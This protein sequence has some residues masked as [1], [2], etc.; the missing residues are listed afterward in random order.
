MA[1]NEVLGLSVNVSAKTDD[2]VKA[3]QN[4]AKGAKLNINT[5]GM[6]DNFKSAQAQIKGMFA[7]TVAEAAS[8]GL[9]KTKVEGF[10]KK[11]QPLTDEIEKS[12]KKSF[13][14]D[15]A[16]RKAK[17]G[18]EKYEKIK[19]LKAEEDTRLRM[20]HARLKQEQV[21]SEKILK[22]R[23]EAI[24]EAERLAARTMTEAAEEAGESLEKAFNDIKG[25]NLAGMFKGVGKR[26]G[27]F[28]AGLQEKGEAAGGMKGD[29]LKSLGKILG[30]LG[31]GL[32]AIGALIAGFA[33]LVKIII[34]AD[35]AA[36]ELHRTLLENGTS[37][38][39][40]TNKFGDVTESLATVRDAFT[41]LDF[42]RTWGTTAKDH[43]SVLNAYA[44]AGRT[45]K[46][47]TGNVK[48]TAQQMNLL[49]EATAGAVAYGKLLG[50][51][52]DTMAEHIGQMM[53]EMAVSQEGALSNFSKI[54]KAA[55]ESGFS[56]K[57]FFNMVLQATSGMAMYNVRLEDT[58]GLLLK[59]TKVLGAKAGAEFMEKLNRGY[60][61]A[62]T[63]ERTKDALL[64]GGKGVELA[65]GE[66]TRQAESLAQLVK[67]F[68]EDSA[69][70][71]TTGGAE[72]M[73]ALED[74][75]LAKLL[76]DPKALAEALS[77]M[78]EKDANAL[79]AKLSTMNADLAGKFQSTWQAALGNK[80]SL[81]GVQAS[82]EQFG[83][84]AT[85][86]SKMYKMR[87]VGID[88]VD[89]VSY[90]DIVKRMG[91]EAVSGIS[92][93]DF[94]QMKRLGSL[95]T[96]FQTNLA[97]AQAKMKANPAESEKIAEDF[98]K[99]FGDMFEARLT[100]SGGLVSTR[101]NDVL[102]TDF[103]ALMLNWSS[104]VEEM[105]AGE[106]VKEDI[107]LAQ[108]IADNTTDMTKILEQGVEAMLM[109]IYTVISAI[110]TWITGGPDEDEKKA[111]IQLMTEMDTSMSKMYE[112]LAA[113]RE[114]AGNAIT[115]LRD[116]KT[117]PERKAELRKTL[118][119]AKNEQEGIRARFQQTKK[120]QKAV[121][122]FDEGY[123]WFGSYTKDEIRQKASEAAG[124][125]ISTESMS[126][127]EKQQL[128]ARHQELEAG[129]TPLEE[130][131]QE[132]VRLLSRP[133]GGKAGLMM[134]DMPDVDPNKIRAQ[135]VAGREKQHQKL[136][137]DFYSEALAKNL[138]G[139]LAGQ[140]KNND[141]QTKKQ[142]T[143][144]KK[145]LKEQ[146]DTL[147]NPLTKMRDAS[148]DD[149][150]ASMYSQLVSSGVSTHSA[151][152]LAKGL[153][154][155]DLGAMSGMLT[156]ELKSKIVSNPSVAGRTNPKLLESL[157][158]SPAKDFIMHV[159]SNGQ[160]KF[161]QRIDGADTVAVA[162]KAG[163]GIS[164]AAGK[165]GGGVTI[166]QH[167]YS[168]MEAVQKG[169]RAL[170]AAKAL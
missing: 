128:A 89:K 122:D 158:A 139:S 21:G 68:Q 47:I 91:T 69:K 82:M 147:M 31:P 160:V 169:Y 24:Q 63:Q 146:T 44:K 80:G 96:G 62:S 130:A 75:K 135:I 142:L 70:R 84:S 86:L 34:D 76:D 117:S 114:K 81:G 28:G 94:R 54:A 51:T 23:R 133:Q 108:V 48:D 72:F 124:L 46:E 22:R 36:K 77:K 112:E 156:P 55:Q 65:R 164:Q 166:I 127:A 155:G 59:L 100:K 118:K 9:S 109:R 58:V 13:R 26:A 71:G 35:S 66:A 134:G 61:D 111:Q 40:L 132:R 42:N 1:I 3:L 145:N 106:Q 33:A 56:T 25:G 67:Q 170:M 157:A 45:F 11:F 105:M 153:R 83:A 102:G 119:E 99:Q 95:I 149:A 167:N 141:D 19:A 17:E 29:A 7:K 126:P 113:S 8:V 79:Y 32:L 116:P 159:G 151:L 10:I 18:T 150:L 104:K 103:D 49:R 92:S 121:R 165:G 123:G 93:E 57:R 144:D 138:S 87:G 107:E 50:E 163:G 148:E 125:E 27:A 131:V 52:A 88:R 129:F 73:K 78:S 6:V 4:A 101:T 16:M 2:F 137:A 43:I 168:G 154:S 74:S 30:A 161:A 140:K 120:L 85:L 37:A 136:D 53:E 143:G 152:A 14:L 5:S 110:K 64:L 15:M 41:N 38:L 162:A 115:E 98:N 90:E 60:K 20:L 39:D 97:E 12:L